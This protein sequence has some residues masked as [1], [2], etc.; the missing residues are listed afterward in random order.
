[1]VP[2]RLEV[3][4]VM[5]LDVIT[6]DEA[7]PVSKISEDMEVTGIGSVVITSE[8]KPAG[9]VTD[10]GIASKVI[11]KDKKASEIK[12][13]E[14]M[15]SPLLTIKPEASVEHAC[16]SLSLLLFCSQ[17]LQKLL[18]DR[19]WESD[20]DSFFSRAPTVIRQPIT[21]STFFPFYLQVF[22]A[23]LSS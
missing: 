22:F 6:E 9:M 16:E 20:I 11:M 2:E 1:M 17:I 8:G 10:R 3:G 18:Q 19:Y 4:D 23:I 7:T 5:T 15:S 21:R 12:A 14:I 13:K